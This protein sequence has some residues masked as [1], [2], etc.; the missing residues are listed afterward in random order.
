MPTKEVLDITNK[1]KP[2]HP[3]S[4]ITEPSAQGSKRK[5]TEGEGD[6]LGQAPDP[7]RSSQPNAEK[8]EKK[9]RV[10]D[11]RRAALGFLESMEK[12][13]GEMGIC[14][15]C[16]NLAHDGDCK[17]IEEAAGNEKA[18]KMLRELLSSDPVSS[19]EDMGDTE[20]PSSSTSKERKR[21]GQAG[22]ETIEMYSYTINLVEMADTAEGGELQC[23]GVDLTYNP[24][25]DNRTFKKTLEMGC[26]TIPCYI[27][28]YG[29]VSDVHLP[30]AYASIVDPR[31]FPKGA[32]LEQVDVMQ[33][34][35]SVNF[36]VAPFD[37]A[38]LCR[39][40]DDRSVFA[41]KDQANQLSHDLCRV[42]RHKIG[43]C[44]GSAFRCDEGGWVDID[45]VIDDRNND[46]FPPNTSRAKRYMGIMEVIKWQESGSKKSR[47]QV[48]AARFPS[49]M[50]PNDTRAAREE[51]TKAGMDRDDID[52]MFNRC[53]GWYRPW[54]IRVTTGHS[55]F[56]FMSSA[57]RYSARMGDSLGGAFHVTYVENLPSIVRCGLVPGGIDGGNRLALHFGAFAPWDEMNVATKVTLRNVRKGDPIA[58]IYIPSATLARYG[59]GVAA[60][61]TFMVF[62]VIPFYEVKSIWIGKSNGGKR[63]EYVDI[64]RAYSKCV[65]NEICPGFVNSSQESA[66]M[67]LQNVT[68]ISE[69]MPETETG[70]DNL[71]Y[72]IDMVDRACEL[73][74][75]NEMEEFN[76]QVNEVRDEISKVVI[77]NDETWEGLRC[78]ICPSCATA[79][80][81]CF[82]LCLECEAQ[83]I[84]T[85]R[86]YININSDDEE[87][88]QNPNVSGDAR[89]AQEEANHDAA[90]Q[91]DEDEA[92]EVP[93][94]DDDMDTQGYTS[95]YASE[96]E[97]SGWY[98]RDTD[99]AS[100]DIISS[101][102]MA[103]CLDEPREAQYMAGFIALQM[104]KMWGMFEGGEERTMNARLEGRAGCP[105]RN[106]F[107][108]YPN[109]T[110]HDQEGI[111]LPST[112]KKIS[113]SENVRTRSFRSVE[114]REDYIRMM[115]CKC[116]GL[117]TFYKLWIAARILDVTKDEMKLL[118]KD[119][120]HPVGDIIFRCFALAFNCKY[121]SFVRDGLNLGKNG[122]TVNVSAIISA[123]DPNKCDTPLLDWCLRKGRWLPEDHNKK[124]VRAREAQKNLD[125]EFRRRTHR[126]SIG[127]RY[128][129]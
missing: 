46:I 54:C 53:D 60:N 29:D 9:Q 41:T 114:E 111:L 51:M 127:D 123:I 48:L 22:K 36:C 118:V 5:A 4:L 91:E 24:C 65:E 126:L 120:V 38:P 44:R 97:D 32:I 15:K 52:R 113:Q 58:I 85:G 43:S 108:R 34:G 28:K 107:K 92:E 89:R 122:Y 73:Y 121:I 103:I 106:D 42:L 102:R 99:L 80:P 96:E 61:G 11:G 71:H 84:S 56:G 72:I 55:D 110:E 87:D 10:I 90:A 93:G 13:V 26:D 14:M 31:Y 100:Q 62:D 19:D 82:C 6:G 67:F 75:N 125:E 47:F 30:W 79:I 16:A 12:C 86:Y 128:A 78:R 124:C 101:Q 18:M 1:V 77:L 25:G 37:G 8:E 27:P 3:R 7:S 81:T 35:K 63:L 83:L 20:E 109:I 98:Y 68:K 59:A 95:G 21:G 45:A 112:A 23:G 74:P 115:V 57:N 33:L 40:G 116:E 70:A 64:K 49:I 39:I 17:D 94:D 66:A 119:R 105:Y 117:Y 2:R 88:N 129:S 69:R 76:A 50:N 104:S